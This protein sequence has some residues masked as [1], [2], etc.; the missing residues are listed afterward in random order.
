MRA[1]IVVDNREAA[2]KEAG[3]IVVPLKKGL[4]DSSSIVGELGQIVA[5]EMVR[6][7]HSSPLHHDHP[8]H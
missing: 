4:I 1:Q 6:R 3:D 5:E 8:R 7:Q 2:L